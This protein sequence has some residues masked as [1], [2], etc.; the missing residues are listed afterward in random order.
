MIRKAF[1]PVG[2]SINRNGEMP[3]SEKGRLIAWIVHNPATE[4]NQHPQGKYKLG[5]VEDFCL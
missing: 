3:G 2:R 1:A 4:R 5:M